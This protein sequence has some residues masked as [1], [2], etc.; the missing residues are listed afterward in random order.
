MPGP[1]LYEELKR[2]LQGRDPTKPDPNRLGR[3]GFLRKFSAP[4]SK[5]TTGGEYD[6]ADPFSSEGSDYLDYQVLYY[7]ATATS[8]EIKDLLGRLSLQQEVIYML[9]EKDVPQ[10]TSRDKLVE[11]QHELDGTPV[12]VDG[13]FVMSKLP[14]A[15]D[16]VIE[17]WG[18]NDAEMVLYV[19]K[20]D[21]PSNQN[22]SS[23]V[24]R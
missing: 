6:P 18:D 10:P 20:P 1:N 9:A 3:I 23:G 11:I 16:S 5:V 14:I 17:L 7:R 12:L 4:S 13:E 19:L 2:L 22:V 8:A 21:N 24:T 15:I